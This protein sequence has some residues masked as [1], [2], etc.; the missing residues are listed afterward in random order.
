MNNC[1]KLKCLDRAQIK[2]EEM[3]MSPTR[4]RQM[5]PSQ[6]TKLSANASKIPLGRP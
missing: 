4:P 6:S 3:S 1:F 5:H 2:L